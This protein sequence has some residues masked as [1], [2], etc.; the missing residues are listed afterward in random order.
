MVSHRPSV[1]LSQFQTSS[2]LKPLD[3][4]KPNFMWRL[5]GKGNE[6]LYK[7]SRS[8]DQDCRHAH[9][10]P[11]TPNWT[12]YILTLVQK[13]KIGHKKPCFYKQ[14]KV[15]PRLCKLFHLKITCTFCTDKVRV[16]VPSFQNVTQFLQYRIFH[17]DSI[18]LF[19]VCL[20]IFLTA[21]I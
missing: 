1:V 7:W 13:A 9:T 5:L 2:P 6:S 12:L 16:K 18:R 10:L 21:V 19:F 20:K 11:P 3:Q 14:T 8:H 17:R 15:L 4:S